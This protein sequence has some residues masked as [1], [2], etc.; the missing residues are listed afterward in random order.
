MIEIKDLRFNYPGNKY[1]VFDGFNL[2]LKPNYVYGLLGKNGTGKS[3]L[4]YL[5]AGLLRPKAG[6]VTIDG[7]AT[8]ERTPDMLREIYIVPEEYNLPNL[9]MAQYIKIHKDFYPLFNENTLHRCLEE[10]EMPTEINFKYLS[11]GQKKKI[12][13]SFSIASSCRFLLMDEPTNGLDIPSKAMFRKV[14]AGNLPEGSTLL[15]STHQVHDIEQLLDHVIII[16]PSTLLLNSSMEEITKKYEFTY[17]T[18]N[19]MDESVVYAEPSLQ[20]NAVMAYRRAGSAETP[21]NL[22]LLFNAAILGKL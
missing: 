6:Q 20:G 5:I 7:K 17:R 22:E 11:M 9:T 3:T 8:K 14:V 16:N 2:T 4:L 13:M 1:N 19:E 10:F 21:V 15:I 12:Y 18:A